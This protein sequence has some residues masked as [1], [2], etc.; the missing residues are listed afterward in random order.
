MLK[1]PRVA[2]KLNKLFGAF[3]RDAGGFQA[4]GT[5]PDDSGA[6]SG[7]G[8]FVAKSFKESPKS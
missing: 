8:R 5:Y 3:P 2:G 4:V 7:G 1:F 6:C